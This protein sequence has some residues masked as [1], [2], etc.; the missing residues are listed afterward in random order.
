MEWVLCIEASQDLSVQGGDVCHQIDEVR[1][2]DP[3]F[4]KAGLGRRL[5]HRNIAL[6]GY[7]S[8]DVL[9]LVME[10]IESNSRV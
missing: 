7:C 3:S 10:Y 1:V 6:F 9:A 5:Q 8:N 2:C 4:Q